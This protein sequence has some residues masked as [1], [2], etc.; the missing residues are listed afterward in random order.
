MYHVESIIIDKSNSGPTKSIIG[1]I[2]T[3]CDYIGTTKPFYTK[4][5][6]Y[7]SDEICGVVWG[8]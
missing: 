4:N 6:I 1:T 2:G 7:T 3:D 8:L 5:I